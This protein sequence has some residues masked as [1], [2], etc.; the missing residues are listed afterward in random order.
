VY[1]LLVD[2][3]ELPALGRSLRFFSH[4]GFNLF[5]ICDRDYGSRTGAP[6]RKDVEAAMA[7]AGVACDGGAIRLLTMP[8]ILGYAFNPLSVYFC[9]ARSGALRAIF[10]EVSNTFGQHHSYLVAID[11][12]DKAL[13]HNA[14]KRFY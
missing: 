6:L 13:R 2:L 12:S 10:Y 4:N 3:D 14:P 11:E 9:Y 8:R 5:S 7:Q 1:W